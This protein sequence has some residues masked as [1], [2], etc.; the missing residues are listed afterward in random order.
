[1]DLWHTPPSADKVT[2]NDHRCHYHA[3]SYYCQPAAVKCKC[4]NGKAAKGAMCAK[5]KSK[6]FEDV[7]ATCNEG[8][9]LRSNRCRKAPPQ[10]PQP[11]EAVITT[12]EAVS[13]TKRGPYVSHDRA[14]TVDLWG[15][16]GANQKWKFVKQGG[17]VY[18]IAAVSKTRRG[19][20]I[21][22]NGDHTVDLWTQAG[23]NQK[24]RIVSQ[25]GDEYTI[26]AI[27][28][29]KRGP[30]LSHDGDKTVDLWKAA[31]GNQKWRI[32]GLKPKVPDWI[33][34]LDDKVPQLG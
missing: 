15:K 18:T 25:G 26:A 14:H 33:A 16:A 22:H 11:A 31:G 1:M 5:L 2:F 6:A 28:K 19:P 30:Y 32:P 34:T 29:T 21:S 7:C 24:W 20:Y 17:N 27:S 12:I 3:S 9:V 4:R 23:A 8:Y 10:P 13:K